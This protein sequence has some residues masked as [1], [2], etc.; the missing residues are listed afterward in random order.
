M[1]IEEEFDRALDAG[2]IE[3]SHTSMARGYVSR[4][5]VAPIQIAPYKGRFGQGFK[6]YSPNWGST[7]YCFV[8]YWL[9]Q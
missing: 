6:V 1:S 9:Y 4:R 2:L 8:T 7:L 3:K 5:G